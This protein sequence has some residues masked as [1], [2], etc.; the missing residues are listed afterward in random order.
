[1]KSTGMED[2]Y[3]TGS[4]SASSAHESS[5]AS[6][7]ATLDSGVVGVAFAF[8]SFV[9]A[10]L[11]ASAPSLLLA[12]VPLLEPGGGL[13]AVESAA[14]QLGGPALLPS[15]WVHS[16]PAGAVLPALLFQFPLAPR[17]G[18]GRRGGQLGQGGEGAS[19]GGGGAPGVGV[20]GGWWYWLVAGGVGGGDGG[21][22]EEGKGRWRTTRP[23][24]LKKKNSHPRPGAPRVDDEHVSRFGRQ[25]CREQG[26]RERQ[27]EQAAE[28]Q[29]RR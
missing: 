10:P 13:H 19:R 4:G 22:K 26:Q 28:E 27:G 15:S 9:S 23:R 17:A 16:P 18:L 1:M 6:A 24:N 11:P 21:E 14:G 3:E 12:A 25:G 29:R 8:V 5:G 7:S 20:A 2:E